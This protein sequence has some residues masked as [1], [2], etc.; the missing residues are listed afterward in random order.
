MTKKSTRSE[1]LRRIGDAIDES[2]L[3]PPSSEL[4]EE[5]A[6]QDLDPDKVVAEMDGC[7][8]RQR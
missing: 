8:N 6:A 7:H 2:I 4:R 3:N 1:E 5:I